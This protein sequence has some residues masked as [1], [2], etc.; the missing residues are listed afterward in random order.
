M[1]FQEGGL[2]TYFDPAGTAVV[3]GSLSDDGDYKGIFKLHLRRIPAAL[4]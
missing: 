1:I 4:H 3:K 2:W